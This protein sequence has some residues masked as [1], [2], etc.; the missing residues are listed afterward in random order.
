MKERRASKRGA[1]Q[2]QRQK[3]RTQRHDIFSPPPLSLSLSHVAST[4][5]QGG[6]QSSHEC[7]RATIDG[8]QHASF[9]LKSEFLPSQNAP[10]RLAQS[11]LPQIGP[12]SAGQHTSEPSR[13]LPPTTPEPWHT[14]LKSSMWDVTECSI[15]GE[16]VSP[17][18]A[19][20]E[21]V[22]PCG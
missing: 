3:I 14:R 9:A 16:L 7:F 6:A 15:G 13:A 18:P 8:T 10:G 19:S 21:S 4:Y 22:C 20:T 5:E 12:H 11:M 17:I 1:R 2:T